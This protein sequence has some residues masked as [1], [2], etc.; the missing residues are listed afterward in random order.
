[1]SPDELAHRLWRLA[2]DRLCAGRARRAALRV[3]ADCLDPLASL[4][5]LDNETKN[6]W[7]EAGLEAQI[8][9]Q[10]EMVLRGEW[11]LFGRRLAL[12]E[13][14]SWCED[15]SGGQA[16]GNAVAAIAPGLL[17]ASGVDIRAIWE[18]NRLQA[19]VSL[20][21][22]YSLSGDNLYAARAA[23]LIDN[24]S[25][26]NPYLRSPNWSNALE[27]ALRSFSLLQTIALCHDSEPFQNQ[28]FGQSLAGLL[29][30]HGHYLNTHLSRGSIALN[31]L[32]VEA[33][34]LTTLGFGLGEL[35]GAHT[36]RRTGA[37]NLERCLERLVLEDGG[38]LE[39]SL[40]YL[41]FSA[42][43]AVVAQSLAGPHG[44][45]LSSRGRERLALA[46]RFLSA[47]TDRGMAISEFGDS[48]SAAVAGPP[49]ALER[50][51]YTRALNLLWMGLENEPLRHAF[52][53][54]PDSARLFG[55]RAFA[56]QPQVES[57]PGLHL[58]SFERSG[59]SVLRAPGLFLRFECG[60]WGAPPCHAH[61]HADRLSFSLFLYGLPFLVDPGT[62]SYLAKPEMREYLRSTAAHNCLSLEGRSQAA[63]RAC[64]FQPEPVWSELIEAKTCESRQAVLAGQAAVLAGHESPRHTRRLTMDLEGRK[65]VLEDSLSG[66]GP[67]SRNVEIGFVFH[68]ACRVSGPQADN[69]ALSVENGAHRLT[70]QPDP[71][72]TASLHRG[73]SAPL[74]GWFSRTFGQ[75]EP[76]QQAVLSARVQGE[77]HFV[78]RLRWE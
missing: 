2:A 6:L 45:E 27:A 16:G 47:A 57:A 26:T 24:W 30:L 46:Y 61:A 35:P 67:D 63:P 78:T 11:E 58:E 22:A 56:A 14:P 44:F 69:G 32:A 62:G 53:P 13:F 54:D 68:P 77:A 75:A 73:E 15:P 74:R 72:C 1:M 64:F 43:A 12:G 49:A 71:R 37:V 42:E 60:H 7:R 10:A 28:R 76:C 19:L 33:A 4:F 25:K 5:P 39:G 50:E 29:F 23:A 52:R 48:D 38:P 31:H 21:Q 55:T 36:W 17:K 9:E 65:L 41:A 3:E 70:I 40:H 20:G 51:R 34:A 66:L 59:H 18:L 8:I